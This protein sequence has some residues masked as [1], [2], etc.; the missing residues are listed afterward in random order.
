V[1][2][3]VS[4]TLRIF[5]ALGA[6]FV[7]A[8]GVAACG[9]DD[10]DKGVPSNA[11]ATV[12]GDPI[13]RADYERWLAINARQSASA[14]GGEPVIPDPP[15]YARCIA[16]L[17]RQAARARGQRA[18]SETQ[19]RSQCR[20]LDTQLSQQT[21]ALLIQ[22]DWIE[23]EAKELGV[24]VTDAEIERALRE[25]RRQSFPDDR[26]YERFLRESGMTE[27]DIRFRLR[28]QE[29]ST[30]ITEQIQRSAGEVTDAEITAYY[31]RN[32]EQFA[33]PERR[34]LEIILTRTRAQAEEAKR[35]IE[36]GGMSWAEAA[37]DFSTDAVSRGNGGR[38]A[39]VARGQQDRALDTAAFNARRGVIVGPV[40]GQFGWYIVRV[41]GITPAKQNTLEQSRAQIRELLEQ[42]GGSE[43]L[44]TFARE[45]QERWT[46]ATECRRGFIIPI[47]SNA[48]RANTTSTAGGTVAG[49][50]TTE[51]R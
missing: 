21:M 3:S 37:R 13:T 39:G 30:K 40:R 14:S 16:T 41:T 15:S 27:D 29:L 49:G 6:F 44:N 11:V 28:I 35:A 4:K 47:C 38:L 31:N 22:S 26:A 36:S 42:Q 5:M 9:G 50:S 43:K 1:L 46:E 23:R 20:T 10:D 34:D 24:E 18:P 7:L 25:T 2:T 51:Q 48:P 33:V 12:D 32:R 45:F 8:F 19:L 17:R